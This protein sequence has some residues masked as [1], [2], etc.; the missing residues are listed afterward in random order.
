MTSLI[1][2]FN[3]LHIASIVF[4]EI[5]SPALIRLIVELLI[6]PFT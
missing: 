1:S 5:D 6:F 3:I 4:V 2:H